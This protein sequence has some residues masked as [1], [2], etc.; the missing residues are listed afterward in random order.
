MPWALILWIVV[1]VLAF[2]V[3]Q[4]F[5]LAAVLAWGDQQTQ[6]LAYYGR[7]APERARF[8]ET[9]RSQARMLYPIL[10]LFGRLSSFSFEKASFRHR[11]VAGPQG[12]CSPESFAAADDYVPRA[13]DV[14]VATQMKC[15]T[16]WMQHVVY[17]VLHRGAGNLVE[18]GTALYAVC[19]WL[20]A[21]K[22]VPI[23]DAPLL[24]AGKPSRVIKTHLPA[25]L[26]PQS[27]D[28]KYIYVARHPVSCFASCVDFIG[29]NVGT[30]RPELEAIERWY[31][32]DAM[33]WGPWTDHVS[34][35]WQLSQKQ[36]N[37][38]FV[39]FEDM[40]KDLPRVV[41]QVAEFLGVEPLNDDEL[42]RVVTKCSF[43]Y[44]QE[45]KEAFEM[46]PPHLLA[47]D[48]ELFVRGTSDRYKDVPQA[49]RDRIREWSIR[50]TGDRFPL[51]DLYPDLANV[52]AG[53]S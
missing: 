22:S 21:R 16:T 50:E 33:W 25:Q 15:G 4:W 31:C 52:E 9:L 10:R 20:E 13:G 1:L 2:L 23:A 18:S 11:D 47:V 42:A 53:G 19:P 26:C 45:H 24:G 49:T 28:A 17:E 34:G 3:V 5:I 37:V 7:P 38:L 27:P 12:T 29:A 40:K 51:A 30:F 43:G 36:E 32:S 39:R 48:S 41:R 46:H 44:M 14:F 6:G 8:R 35:W